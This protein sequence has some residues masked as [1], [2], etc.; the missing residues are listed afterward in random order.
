MTEARPLLTDRTHA[1]RCNKR[2][3]RRP[4]YWKMQQLT[5]NS[6]V[7]WLPVYW[8]AANIYRFLPAVLF[9]PARCISLACYITKTL[10]TFQTVHQSMV[11]PLATLCK[12]PV[13]KSVKET[14]RFTV[15]HTKIFTSYLQQLRLTF[16]LLWDYSICIV[17]SLP[18]HPLGFIFYAYDTKG[19][20]FNNQSL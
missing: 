11:I 8:C 19:L 1:E 10:S 2:V 5:I 16:M 7:V 9:P 3:P 18:K 17:L 15:T 6:L 13:A 12:H 14:L 4:W 20:I